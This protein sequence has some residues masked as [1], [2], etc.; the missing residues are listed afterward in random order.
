MSD[1]RCQGPCDRGCAAPWG[2][3]EACGA[4]ACFFL[5]VAFLRSSM[6][7]HEPCVACL[8]WLFAQSKWFLRRQ[9][10]LLKL[11]RFAG[12]D[13]AGGALGHESQLSWLKVVRLP[14]RC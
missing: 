12:C 3:N 10:V 6:L 13:K 4:V 2:A 11:R 7:M 8:P 9:L 14:P 5:L 1:V